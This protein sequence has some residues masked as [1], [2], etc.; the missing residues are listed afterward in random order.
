MCYLYQR[1]DSDWFDAEM[2]K[3]EI[4]KGFLEY[5][6]RT[7]I[8]FELAY[9]LNRFSNNESDK[10]RSHSLY[11]SLLTTCSVSNYL[12]T[13]KYNYALQCRNG[14]G[15]EKDVDKAIYWLTN[16]S[17]DRYHDAFVELIDIY[18]NEEG[19]QNNTQSGL[20]KNLLDEEEKNGGNQ[21]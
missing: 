19:Y 10:Q 5:P 1:D 17:M 2:A 13:A 7:E 6:R 15:C 14:I 4:E 9:V 18:N 16:A 21:K 20:W 12:L 8:K 11:E 3:Q